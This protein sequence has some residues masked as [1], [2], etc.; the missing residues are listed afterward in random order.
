M[1]YHITA[2]P[3]NDTRQLPEEHRRQRQLHHR[4]RRGET[5]IHAAQEIH[6][7]TDADGPRNTATRMAKARRI[8]RVGQWRLRWRGVHPGQRLRAH[9]SRRQTLL[10]PG[11][12]QG[13]P[14]G[15]HHLQPA[16]KI[17][18]R[19]AEHRDALRIRPTMYR[20]VRGERENSP[21]FLL[22]DPIFGHRA[23]NDREHADS[24]HVRATGNWKNP[25]GA[26]HRRSLSSQ[27]RVDQP[28]ERDT[29]LAR[30]SDRRGIECRG[31]HRR[32]QGGHRP[33]ESRISQRYMGQQRPE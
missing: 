14:R 6:L 7:R 29:S 4:S 11:R 3:G 27:C 31:S 19:S 33:E 20:R 28:S 32:V 15:H 17:R 25:N 12:I 30:R 18:V 5:A 26:R 13:S 23:R 1:P 24:R 22:H 16:P 8:F 9:Q 2:G 10:P 21:L